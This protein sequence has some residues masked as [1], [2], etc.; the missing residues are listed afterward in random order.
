MELDIGNELS[1]EK[2]KKRPESVSTAFNLLKGKYFKCTAIS[3]VSKLIL[4]YF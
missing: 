2:F 1:K 3:D 4:S